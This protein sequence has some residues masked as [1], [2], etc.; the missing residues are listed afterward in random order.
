[1]DG[2]AL[3]RY[4][5]SVMFGIPQ[6]F[7]RFRLSPP[8]EIDPDSLREE[9]WVANFSRE[10][11][12]RFAPENEPSYESSFEENRLVLRLRKPDCLAW[13][14]DPL[15]RY[16]DFSVEAGLRIDRTGG[17][18][19]AGLL[20]RYSDPGDYYS[21]LVSNRGFFRLDAV[22]NGNPMP[23]IGWTEL[24]EGSDRL[25]A[26]VH[27]AEATRNG[28]AVRLRVIARS[29]RF[30]IV[31]DDAW[32][33]E[34]MDST[35]GAG[36][37]A[38]A[39]AS[40]EGTRDVS[41]RLDS[42]RIDSRPL[43]TEAAHL[44]WNA[45]IR[46]DP[47]AR[48]ALA[49]T[50]SAMGQPLSALVQLKRAWKK[51]PG[52][53]DEESGARR[54]SAELLL[55]ASCAIRLGLLEE[56]EDYLDR[57]VEIDPDAEDARRATAEK[58]KILYMGNRFAELRDHALEAVVLF[59]ADST[60]RTLLGHALWNLGSYAAAAREYDA[61]LELEPSNGLIAQNAGMAWE[62]VGNPDAAFRRYLTAGRAFLAS[63]SYDDLA[64]VIPRLAQLRPKDAAA[65][66]LAGK[67][68]FALGDFARASEELAEAD[69][70]RALN[71]EGKPDAAVPF[72]R[73]L[74]LAKTGK[75]AQALP[76]LERAAALEESYAPFR[77][78]LAETR[79]LSNADPLDP[80]MVA[81]LRAALAAA[82]A[83]GWIL[84][85]AA[86]VALARGDLDEASRHLAKADAA[87]GNQA[88]V[89]VNRAELAFL[90]GDAE[91]ALALVSADSAAVA[92]AAGAGAAVANGRGNILVRLGRYE[93]AD[94]AY[95]T[96]VKAAGD[97]A[98]YLRNRASCLI[99]LSRYGE[100]DEL[101]SMAFDRDPSSCR[102]LELTAY[103]AVK[104]GELPRA[105]AA[106]RVGLELRADDPGLLASLAWVYLAMGRWN[107]AEDAVA[108]LERASREGGPV[109]A[110]AA[111]L[112]KHLTEAT[113]RLVSCATCERSWRVP[114][115]APPIGALRLVAEP[116]DELPAGTCPVCLKTWCIGC[117][118]A[119]V[120]EGR[121]LCPTC[122]ERLKLLDEGLKK[123]LADWS[124]TAA[125]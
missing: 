122:G 113:T 96:A 23:L 80:R 29:D 118:K 94:E 87:L 43:E 32:A 65:R 124:E 38:F 79:F 40:Y 116:P 35:I 19:A 70:L 66:A 45:L 4:K 120:K 101:L 22:F 89:L 24:P 114:K 39:A 26:T 58:A 76:F 110:S 77:F 28:E 37:I 17:Y 86:Q 36:R 106:C 105:E 52:I 111:E 68:Y 44:R 63:E 98:E 123:L 72:L 121:F 2:T 75:R 33:A 50:F 57:C 15:Y 91:A 60:L 49:R 11:A 18:C 85:F 119:S 83:D 95:K 55:A 10:K 13:T 51:P 8:Q 5:N 108:R 81:D 100:A 82:P 31:I 92:A 69:A 59:P 41:A 54:S 84:N 9:R 64:L 104:K 21:I 53:L 117:A 34:V 109:A 73:G 90:R 71:A 48:F 61:A 103:V 78:R 25:P 74:A 1:M 112:R 62:K 102:T 14:L 20:F 56:A 12:R 125:H 6:L 3:L 88:A 97:E 7:A 93:E 27:P 115:D 30:T 16:A 46:V 42:F 99:E 107:G 67:R 47:A